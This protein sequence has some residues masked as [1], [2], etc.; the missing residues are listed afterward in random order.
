MNHGVVIKYLPGEEID[1]GLSVIKFGAPWCPPCV[2]CGPAYKELAQEYQGVVFYDVNVDD[3]SEGAPSSD[4]TQQQVFKEVVERIASLPSFV[5][6]REAKIVTEIK[7]WR[8]EVLRSKLDT[9]CVEEQTSDDS[10]AEFCST[11]EDEYSD[12]EDVQEPLSLEEET[13]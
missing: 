12:V 2:R 13:S 5:I 9:I 8:P 3:F 1:L 6:F 11:E 4:E 7:A 10:Y